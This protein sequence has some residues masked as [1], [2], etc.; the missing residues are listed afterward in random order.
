[1][2]RLLERLSSIFPVR[3]ALT[4][5][6]GEASQRGGFVREITS[7]DE[8]KECMEEYRGKPAFI[9]KHSTS[10]PIS[11]RASGRVGAYLESAPESTPDFLL[12]KV[13]ESRNVSN[14][15]AEELGVSHQSPQLILIDQGK[16][17]W[18]KSH[19]N[20]TADAI[21]QALETCLP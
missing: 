9:F 8:W 16:A 10:C 4:V 20:I 7:L 12:V 17:V 18:N 21:D 19:H 11:S 15:L 2:K 3:A 6:S 5:N 13:I 1:M 14:A